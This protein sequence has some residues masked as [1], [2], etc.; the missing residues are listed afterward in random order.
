MRSL[1]SFSAHRATR[2]A[3]AA[4]GAA[5]VGLSLTVFGG[6]HN[7]A[8]GGFFGRAVGGIS[9]SPE[10]VLS[11]V[12]VADRAGMRKLLTE[13]VDGPIAAAVAPVKMR[14]VSLKAIEA[15]LA[16]VEGSAE[17][18]PDEIKYLAGIQR[19][20]HVFVDKEAGDIVLAGPAEG[21][22]IDAAGN[23]V[24]VTTGRPVV[25]LS[26]LVMALRTTE[27]ARTVGITCS[28]DPTE[29]GRRN[30]DALYARVRSFTP[31]LIPAVR[32]A[33]GPQTITLTGLPTDS[34][35]ARTLVAADY[36]L[37]RISMG[38][39]PTPVKGLANYLEL[40]SAAR[41]APADAMPRWWIACDYRPLVRSTDGLSWTISGP[42]MKV[43]TED[44][45]FTAEGVVGTGRRS[46][47][48]QKL[49]DGFN[50]H[51]D[52]LTAAE[53]IFG[54]LR[55]V[56]DVS[57]TAA[58]IDKQGMFE[59]AG[60]SAPI[61]RGTVAGPSFRTYPV[62]K[63]VDTQVSFVNV[64]GKFVI[65]ASGGVDIDS[66]A[67]VDREPTTADLSATRQQAVGDRGTLWWN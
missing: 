63:T 51:L 42:G 7:N 16:E 6:V 18:L 4:V 28:I 50:A 61:L 17:L 49:A 62:P 20:E 21:W 32:S 29:E 9:I 45:L 53:P 60:L 44:E 11:E 55:T 66:W 19:I 10:G 15:A 33:L 58:L 23:V 35:M 38:L 37:K 54:E 3:A 25:R 14:M 5:V 2:S 8:G 64:G 43:M 47:L 27:T 12:T 36:R 46:P 48:A 57:V 56:M 41:G 1:R 65:T 40:V 52:E 31:A 34:H 24:G 39:E 59:T 26:D 30:L 22:R 13:E 67:V